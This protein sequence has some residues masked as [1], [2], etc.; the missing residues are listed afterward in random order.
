MAFRYSPKI[1]SDGLVFYVDAANPKSFI[2]GDTTWGDMSGDNNGTLTNGPTFDSDNGGSIVFDGT[3]DY[4]DFGDV[5]NFERTDPFS[6]DC[7]VNTNDYTK[8][9]YPISKL[10]NSLGNRGWGFNIRDNGEISFLLINTS[11]GNNQIR[12]DSD[13]VI[14]SNN[15]WYHIVI[16]YDGSSDESGVNIYVN[17]GLI[18]FTVIF[19]NLSSTTIGSTNLQ[20]SGSDGTNSVFDGNISN[21]KIYNKELSSTEVLENYNALKPRF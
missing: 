10:S 12:V 4:V 6:L 21:I 11:G 1:V 2:S 20:I 9:Q 14:T 8:F 16:T 13:A 17:G 19:N 18:N 7:W 15:T 3:D 5:F